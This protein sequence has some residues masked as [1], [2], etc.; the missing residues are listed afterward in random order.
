MAFTSSYG[1]KKTIKDIQM[2]KIIL[3]GAYEASPE[4]GISR[5]VRGI[6]F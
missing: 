3:N 2:V 4:N 6:E 1:T 5:I